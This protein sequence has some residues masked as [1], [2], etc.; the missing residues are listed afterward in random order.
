MPESPRGVELGACL[1]SLAERDGDG[2]RFLDVLAEGAGALARAEIPYLLVGGIASATLGRPR[3]T[4]DID[5][6]V[7]PRDAK[8]A[9]D[10]LGQAGFETEETNPHWIFKAEKNGF[11]I[12]V[13]F[14]IKGGIHLDERMYER[15]LV[16]DLDGRSVRVA[17]PEDLIVTKAVAH[18]E[19]SPRHW[20]DALGVIAACELDWDYLLERAQYGARRV[21]A[22]LVYAQ[23]DDFVVPAWAIERLYHTIYEPAS[24]AVDERDAA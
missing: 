24:G 16:A 6:L 17:A 15:S 2:A 20:H 9:L 8:P 10:A 3:F 1:R 21:L 4:A 22:L 12:D 13:L 7:Q 11:V 14:A 18:D 19:S 23:A 5:F